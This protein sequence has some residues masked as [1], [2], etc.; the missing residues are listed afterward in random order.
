MCTA[1]KIN[2][3]FSSTVTEKMA[4]KTLYKR[5]NDGE[6]LNVVNYYLENY[7]FGDYFLGI[8]E[9]LKEIFFYI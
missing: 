3:I 4:F 5:I 6:L 8:P 2:D 9:L 1:F 7:S